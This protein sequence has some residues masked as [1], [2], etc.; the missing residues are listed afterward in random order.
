MAQSRFLYNER[1]DRE[2]GIFT[3]SF[4]SYYPMM[5]ISFHFASDEGAPALLLAT[6]SI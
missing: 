4:D 1:L 3:F 2:S 5:P 6:S